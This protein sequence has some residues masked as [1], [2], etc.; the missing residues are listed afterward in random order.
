MESIFKPKNLGRE[1]YFSRITA[2]G[3]IPRRKAFYHSECWETTSEQ[4]I[5]KAE[6]KNTNLKCYSTSFKGNAVTN[7]AQPEKGNQTISGETTR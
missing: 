3:I 5:G 7:E 2:R 1:P 6:I 4:G